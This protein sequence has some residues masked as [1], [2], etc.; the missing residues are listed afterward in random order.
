[1]RQVVVFNLVPI[2][3]KVSAINTSSTL[4][5]GEVRILD[6]ESSLS[7]EH[8]RVA[9][10]L[11]TKATRVESLLQKRYQE[12][13]ESRG[14]T[15]KRRQIIVPRTGVSLYADLT[16]EEEK[17]IIEVK[18]STSRSHI[19]EAIGQV[20]DYVF[21]LK[22]IAHETWSPGILLPGRPSEDL[23]EL[24]ISLGIELIWEIEGPDPKFESLSPAK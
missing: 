19:R 8:I 5:S 10:S 3:A 15:V 11:E 23:C 12:Y 6:V 4:D 24:V 7:S 20:L 18:A 21:Q 13:L 16:D 1:M 2:G 9:R 17:R 14:H 22:N